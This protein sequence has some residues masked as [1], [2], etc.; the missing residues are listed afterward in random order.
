MLPLPS[1]VSTWNKMPYDKSEIGFGPDQSDLVAIWQSVR[2]SV[3][4]PHLGTAR[5][6]IRIHAMGAG[7]ANE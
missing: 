6:I 4:T 7:L 5:S 1:S 3:P 2:G